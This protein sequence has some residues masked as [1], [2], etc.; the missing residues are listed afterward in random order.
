[1][2]IQEAVVHELDKAAN[3]PDVVIRLRDACLPINEKLATLG[4]GV[5]KIYGK[6]TNNYGCFDPDQETYRFSALMAHYVSG[7]IP[8][9]DFSQAASRLVAATMGASNA[10]TGGY[11]IFLR[12]TSHGRD[13]L[14]VAMLKLRTGTGIDSQTLDLTDS[15]SFDIS[16]L[17]EAARIDLERW[18][19]NTQPYLSFIKRRSREDVTQYFR[20]ALGCTDYT[21]SRHNTRQAMNAVDAF[22]EAK[23]WTPEQKQNARRAAFNYCDE[24]G[25]RNE[26]VNLSSLSARIFDQEPD[27]FANFVREEGYT[28]SETFSPHKDTYMRF[29]RISGRVGNVKLSFDVDDL[30]NDT[31]AYDAATNSLTVRGLSS[32]LR[33]EI[34]KAQGNAPAA[35]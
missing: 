22:G 34:L 35:D 2:E 5:L 31:I 3:I 15:L 33:D 18:K 6:S 4:D 32:T 26:H 17:H 29:Q 16:H 7:K 12:Y 21:D 30:L 25:Q 11:P 10:A 27:A 9:L 19:Q 1:M 24:N 14:L 13:W 8:L 20:L 28:V 23:N